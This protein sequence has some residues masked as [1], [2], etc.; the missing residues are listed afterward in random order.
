MP[1]DLACDFGNRLGGNLPYT[2]VDTQQ[3]SVG[4]VDL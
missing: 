2:E 4:P 3:S 1:A